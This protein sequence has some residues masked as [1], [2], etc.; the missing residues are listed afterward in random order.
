MNRSQPTGRLDDYVLPTHISVILLDLLKEEGIQEADVLAGTSL[1]PNDIRQQNSYISYQQALRMVDNAM[2]LSKQPGLG[3]KVGQREKTSSWG[4]L[5]FT[6]ASCATLGDAIEIGKRY[7]QTSEALVDLDFLQ[8]DGNTLLRC[9]PPYPVGELLQFVVE[10]ALASIYLVFASWLEAPL[11]LQEVRLAYDRP[12]YAALYD[13]LFDCP[14]Y[15]NCPTN[16]MVFDTSYLEKPL[17]QA[18]PLTAK[19]CQKYLENQIIEQGQSNDLVRNVRRILL[20][21]PGRFPGMDSVAEELGTSASSMRRHLQHKGL[22]YQQVLDDVR[23]TLAVE[24]LE[25]TNL[26]LEEIS[27]LAGFSE[28]SN[29]RRAFKRWTG[30][31]PSYYRK[32]GGD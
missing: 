11:R 13:K 18:D 19:Q 9:F 14:V 10:D 22:S 31:P 5:G 26:S 1:R 8:E 2:Q 21:S 17:L 27:Q 32:Q 29:F 12:G 24:Y 16:D 30:H 15:F 20:R 23:A 28:S 6:M 4:I 25:S 3:L 7:Y